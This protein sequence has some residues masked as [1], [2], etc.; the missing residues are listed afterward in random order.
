MA[1]AVYPFDLFSIVAPEHL[2]IAP[3]DQSRR[4]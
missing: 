1:E 4:L 3:Y 2:T